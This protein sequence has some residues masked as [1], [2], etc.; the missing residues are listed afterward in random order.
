VWKIEVTEGQQ[1]AEGDTLMIVESMKMEFPVKAASAGTVFKIFAREGSPV[2]A[3]QDVMILE[4]S[5][6]N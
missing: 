2:S 4:T 1:V 5:T 3:G 6:K